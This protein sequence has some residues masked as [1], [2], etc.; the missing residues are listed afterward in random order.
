M[1]NRFNT[2]RKSG[3]ASRKYHCSGTPRPGL[4]QDSPPCSVSSSLAPAALERRPLD[5]DSQRSSVS[6]WSSSTRTFGTLSYGRNNVKNGSTPRG[7][8]S[9]R[10][11]GYL[12]AT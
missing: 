3:G 12:V 10:T 11:P 5:E 9:Q 2:E 6:P 8:S 4:R 1:K 7:F